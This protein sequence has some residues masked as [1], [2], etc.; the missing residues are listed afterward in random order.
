MHAAG[1]L[2]HVVGVGL[3]LSSHVLGVRLG[4]LEPHSGR[5]RPGISS[6]MVDV[7]EVYGLSW[8]GR[9]GPTTHAT[10][11]GLDPTTIELIARWRSF[12]AASRRLAGPG[13]RGIPVG[14]WR[15]SPLPAPL[16]GP[17]A[18]TR[19]GYGRGT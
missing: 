13:W 6:V 12:E 10:N 2:W 4:L 9:W 11:Q 7:L 8:L 19:G 3:G 14:Q 15:E 16:S 17:Q 1:G 18:E 5:V